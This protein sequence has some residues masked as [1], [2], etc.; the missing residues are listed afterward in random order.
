MNAWNALICGC[1]TA[2]CLGATAQAQ[3][4]DLLSGASPDRVYGHYSGHPGQFMPAEMFSGW[5]DELGLTGQQRT[6]IQI[7]LADYGPRFRDLTQLGRDTATK[8]LE[9]PPDDAGYI[10]MTQEASALAASSV[11]ELIT[12]LAEMRGKLYAVLTPEQR[13]QIEV[14]RQ[15]HRDAKA[16][17]DQAISEGE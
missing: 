4:P 6:D 14:L 2:L 3:I 10:S 15:A 1:L 17:E 9:T 16:T 8:L 12:L 11:A 7:I 13:V 5:A